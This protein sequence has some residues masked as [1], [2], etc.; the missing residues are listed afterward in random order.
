MLIN[1]IVDLTNRI[2]HYCVF[3]YRLFKSDCYYGKCR[4]KYSQESNGKEANVLA[5][6]PSLNTEMP[7]IMRS[8]RET[9]VYGVVNFFAA[10]NN[11][12]HIKPQ[13]YFLADAGFFTNN[14]RDDIRKLFEILNKEVTWVMTVV[15]PINYYKEAQNKLYNK[16]IRIEPMPILQYETSDKNKMLYLKTGKAAPSYVNVTIF[17]EFYFLNKG[18]KTIHL[19]GVDHTFFSD[20]SVDSENNIVWKRSHFYESGYR[21]LIRYKEDG[22]RWKLSDWLRDKYLTFREHEFMNNYASFVGARIINHTE[23]SMI[24][25][26]DR[27]ILS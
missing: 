15:V 11:F 3:R 21:K 25:A 18:Y 27:E 17:V 19:F 12:L 8:D 16:Y 10:T 22:T 23:H 1:R 2:Y 9:N 24:D 20:M 4:F 6:G 7:M 14:E 13:Y 5:T 26:Y